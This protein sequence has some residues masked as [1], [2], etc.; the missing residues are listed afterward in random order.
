MIFFLEVPCVNF[1]YL[2]FDDLFMHIW[3]YMR[4]D[5]FKVYLYSYLLAISN[6]LFSLKFPVVIH[7]KY[8]WH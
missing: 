6:D 5:I 7:I 2:V 8:V 3:D 4:E 1:H